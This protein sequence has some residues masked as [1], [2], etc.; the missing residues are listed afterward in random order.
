[1]GKLPGVIILYRT[2]TPRSLFTRSK[3]HITP[4]ETNDKWQ[5]SAVTGENGVIYH[6]I[7]GNFFTDVGLL[8]YNKTQQ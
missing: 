8:Y 5:T 1:M 4:G 6:V 7:F 2:V 3:F